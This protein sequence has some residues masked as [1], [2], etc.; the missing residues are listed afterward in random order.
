MSMRLSLSRPVRRPSVVLVWIGV[1]LAAAVAILAIGRSGFEVQ[2][3]LVTVAIVCLAAAFILPKAV[4]RDGKLSLPFVASALALHLVGSLLRY[5]IIQAVYH[6]VADA[7]GYFGAGKVFAPLFRT[8]QFPAL[9]APYF[10]TPFV[11]WSTGILFAIIGSSLLG[12]FGIHSAL[13]FVG[14]WYFYKAF[15]LAF[16]D[17]D[18]KLFAWLLF[19]L[20]SMW[21]WPSSLG[22]DSLVVMFLGLA[23]YGFAWLFRGSTLRGVLPAAVG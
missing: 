8:L 15:R 11:N 12:G 16:P 20:P 21:Y 22:K 6:G 17:G 4:A 1:L 13:A 2:M 5:F 23:V 14:G 19:F 18:S 3:Y 7:N 9:K 10:G